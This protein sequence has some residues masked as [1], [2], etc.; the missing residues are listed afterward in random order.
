MCERNLGHNEPHNVQDSYSLPLPPSPPCARSAETEQLANEIVLPR[1]EF[2]TVYPANIEGT[3]PL[4]RVVAAA[5]M[6]PPP[7]L[8]VVAPPPVAVVVI[9]PPTRAPTQAATAPAVA[10]AVVEA[11][12]SA[13]DAFWAT[14]SADAVVVVDSGPRECLYFKSYD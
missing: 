6:P 7:P 12:V 4:E 3:P 5:P 14:P 9:A 2:K 11:S 1:E 13:A 10:A 8:P